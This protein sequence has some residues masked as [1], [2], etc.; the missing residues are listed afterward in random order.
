MR[1][2]LTLLYL[3]KI[4]IA[5]T[6]I[7]ADCNTVF[8]CIDSISYQK[9][10]NH[11]FIKDTLFFCK[12]SSTTTTT[13]NYT[14]KYAIGKSATLEFLA[15]NNNNKLLLGDH[16][17]D[18][19]IEYKTRKVGDLLSLS[20]IA[21]TKKISLDTSTTQLVDQD[22]TL[23]WYQEIF[24]K[25]ENYNLSILE[26]SPDYLDYIGFSKAE[27]NQSMTYEY[28]NQ[29]LSGGRKYPRQF[30]KI[31]AINIQI[32]Q[33]GLQ[34]LIAY[35]SLIGLHKKGNRFLNN[36]FTIHYTIVQKT[37]PAKTNSI[38]I[39]LIDKQRPQNITISNQVKIEVKEY[40]CTIFL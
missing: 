9:I 16:L 37:K 2:F 5:Q 6:N 21:A 18:F 12:E 27:I 24:K 10:F 13:Q 35:C 1:Y 19:G 8:V 7:Q 14:G 26:Y 32:H 22:T 36:D 38:M 33:D 30:N 39:K 25:K 4:V 40:N 17:H 11:P 29:K 31:S 28:F 23:T 15:P 3:L 34:D 20:K